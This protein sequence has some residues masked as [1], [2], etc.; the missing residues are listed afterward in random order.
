MSVLESIATKAWREE[1]RW[2]P[3]VAV[4]P[5]GE[6]G[7]P[8]RSKKPGKVPC[9]SNG[10]K[11]KDWASEESWLT[12]AQ[13][14]AVV[15]GLP[16]PEKTPEGKYLAGVGHVDGNAWIHVDLDY[17]A[18]DDPRLQ[19]LRESG[20]YVEKGPSG[21]GWHAVGIG[22]D[23]ETV[24]TEVQFFEDRAPEIKKLGRFLT[25]TGDEA[26]GDPSADLSP[27]LKAMWES[28]RDKPKPRT[29]PK[30]PRR[31]AD[32][33]LVAD[34]AKKAGVLFSETAT[35][36]N[37]RC[38]WTEAHTDGKC[39]PTD[40]AFRVEQGVV[41][42][43]KCFH[44]S[45]QEKTLNAALTFLGIRATAAQKDAGEFETNEKGRPLP[46][47]HNVRVVLM[48]EG[49]NLARNTFT[50]RYEVVDEESGTAR[51]LTDQDTRRWYVDAETKHGL[52]IG[53]EKFMDAV[54]A[55][56]DERPYH[57]VRRY[58]EE[59]PEWDGKERCSRW[60]IDHGKANDA[61]YVRAVSR[62]VLLAAV[63]RALE[64]GAKFDEMV[65]L[66]SPQG[67]EKSTALR[68]LCPDP[69][70][71][72]ESLHIGSD[73][74]TTIEC[75]SGVW[76]AE[77]AELV[78]SKREVDRLKSFLSTSVD[79]PV[80]LAYAREPVSVPRQFVV[81]GTT[82]S[83]VYLKDLSGG[84]RFWPVSVGRMDPVGIARDRDQ[85]WA[86]AYAAVKAGASIRLERSLWET[87]GEEQRL[88]AVEDPWADLFVQRFGDNP[89]R[90]TTAAT[91][92]I[93]GREA[94]N[95]THADS[96]R[97][98][99][100][101]QYLGFTAKSAMWNDDRTKAHRGWQR[102]DSTRW[103]WDPKLDAPTDPPL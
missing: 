82:N 86:E 22:S 32:S 61:P 65:V 79:G 9:D 16:F 20:C 14:R 91:W 100:V 10:R 23:P 55:L 83:K 68:A 63:K 49:A 38:P 39:T 42:G 64:P 60:L 57:P 94:Q 26:E 15:K 81:I 30:G 58:L 95:R 25:I 4:F 99:G 2:L 17:C 101:L 53:R 7:K 1:R 71:F 92:R 18:S 41:T 13:A 85:M 43:F 8:D 35:D 24:S 59:L 69:A 80:R 34:A 12:Y 87:A 46:S 74:K 102:G 21:T 45:C 56:A 89:G 66:E 36:I 29:A 19:L 28:L 90:L 50:G 88:R 11:L 76:V 31:T 97:L 51:V 33:A 5:A 78:G 96:E 37:I 103:L 48:H 47:F 44:A 72:S 40:A 3:W 73:S 75:T 77:I 93:V 54:Y 62:L 67:Y 84:R 98:A 27:T 6:D 70:W 52:T